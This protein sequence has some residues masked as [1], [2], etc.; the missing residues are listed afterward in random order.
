MSIPALKRLQDDHRHYDGLLCIIDRQL[1]AARCDDRLDFA[2]LCDIFH[3][4]T[5][6]PD[7][8]HHAF[9]D[10]LFERLALRC[11]EIR[12][13]LEL[14]HEEHRR[15]ALYGN[16]LHAKFAAIVD[17]HADPELD[18]ATLNLV[19]VY[20]ELYRAHMRCEE[21]QVLGLL[22]ERLKASDWLELVTTCDWGCDPLLRIDA[23]DEYRALKASIARDRAGLWMGRDERADFC[24]L[25]PTVKPAV[26]GQEVR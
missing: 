18:L 25:C 26:A 4:M 22:V 20:I 1:Y 3:Y 23:D 17:G 7:R 24:P 12:P 19:Q 11:P 6:H 13:T 14:L 15:I 5:R 10:L 9:E 21:S 8:T 16:E 2:L